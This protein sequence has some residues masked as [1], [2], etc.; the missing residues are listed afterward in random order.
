MKS[1][2]RRAVFFAA[3]AL[4]ICGSAA[5]APPPRTLSVSGH[6]E[7]TALPDRARLTLAV[8]ALETEVGQA[9]DRVN[10]AVRAYLAA[11][12]PLALKAEDIATS[13]IS[14][15]PEY[16]WDEQTRQQKLVGYRARRDIQILVRNLDQLGELILRA[17]PAGV[18]HVTPPQLESSQAERLAREALSRAALD[19]K[20]RAEALARALNV[21]LGPPRLVRE[22]G[23]AA[24]VPYKVMAMRAQAETFDGGNQEMGLSTGEIR[25]RADVAVE[26]DLL[27]P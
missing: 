26:F 15:Q 5:A 24:P 21:K 9:Q 20:A 27:A 4:G 22:T 1:S 23:S 16:V 25:I 2:P 12:Q 6:G 18:N 13:G 3:L 14:L 8:D 17:T 7:V 10:R 19:A 11:I